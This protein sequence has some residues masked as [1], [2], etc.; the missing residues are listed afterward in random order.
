[1]VYR[2]IVVTGR[3]Q[4]V[5]FR[6]S[7]RQMAERL[8]LHGYV[9]NLSDGRVEVLAAGDAENVES[10]IKWLK[11]GPKLAKVSNIEVIELDSDAW[12]CHSDSGFSIWPT[13]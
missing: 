7:S 12:P 13:R 3:V 9:R 8:N 10:L 2:K 4:G 11:T 5:F 6:D 1:M